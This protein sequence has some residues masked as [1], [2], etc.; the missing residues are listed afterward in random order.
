MKVEITLAHAMF[1]GGF[2]GILILLY[3]LRKGIQRF[4]C[5][6][7]KRKAA[8]KDYLHMKANA[9][10][11]REAIEE[12]VQR[13]KAAEIDRLS[14]HW[15]YIYETVKTANSVALRLALFEELIFAWS[16]TGNVCGLSVEGIEL[17][18][19]LVNDFDGIRSVKVGK[20]LAQFVNNPY[21]RSPESQ[22]GGLVGLKE[23]STKVDRYGIKL[24]PGE[25]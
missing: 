12:Q 24:S 5:F 14:D 8:N 22:S 11:A 1:T 3:L 20:K 16:N 4:Q 6:Q 25:L 15:R 19:E 10:L 17:F 7:V 9:I 13:Q 21:V 18:M 23:H 2:V